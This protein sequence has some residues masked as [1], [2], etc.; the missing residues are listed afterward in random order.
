MSL[1]I[2]TTHLVGSLEN[3]AGPYVDPEELPRQHVQHI[4]V[5]AATYVDFRSTAADRWD[6]AGLQRLME[7]V[8]IFK[9]FPE[10]KLIL[11][12]GSF[13]ANQSDPDA[14]ADLPVALGIPRSSLVLLT[15]ARDTEHEARLVSKIVGERPFALVTSAIH[16]PRSMAIFRS[17]GMHPIPCP[18]DFQSKKQPSI[19]VRQFIP[20]AHALQTSTDALH[21]YMGLVWF[22]LRRQIKNIGEDLRSSLEQC[23]LPRL[24]YFPGGLQIRRAYGMRT[25]PILL[26]HCK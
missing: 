21:E 14:M 17:L 11:S 19:Y 7:G 23:P 22:R 15:T 3:S 4:V 12:G 16:I 1:P 5:L 25:A 18:C 10:A 6:R 20:S 13:G 24:Q 9:R 8:R 2:V 26:A